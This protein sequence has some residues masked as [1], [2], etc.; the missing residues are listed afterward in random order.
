MLF[1]SQSLIKK[2]IK[3]LVRCTQ[4][5]IVRELKVSVCNRKVDKR[6][7]VQEKDRDQSSTF[8]SHSA[9]DWISPYSYLEEEMATH[10]SFLA[11]RIPWTEEPGG[12]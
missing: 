1:S 10:S 3:S 5:A 4:L 6:Y 11:W 2:K 7:K 8:V 9:I 12:L